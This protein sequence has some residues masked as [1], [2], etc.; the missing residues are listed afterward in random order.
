[1]R[2]ENPVLILITL[3]ILGKRNTNSGWEEGK[4]T[5]TCLS[6]PVKNLSTDAVYNAQD[7]LF[8][9]RVV[10]TD[11]FLS[12]IPMR[13]TTTEKQQEGKD[14]QRQIKLWKLSHT[15]TLTQGQVQSHRASYGKAEPTVNPLWN[16]RR[17]NTT[18]EGG[19]MVKGIQRTAGFGQVRMRGDCHDLL[20]W[21]ARSHRIPLVYACTEGTACWP[22]PFPKALMLSPLETGQGAQRFLVSSFHCLA[23]N[24]PITYPA[25]LG[26]GLSSNG[27]TTVIN[28]GLVTGT[29]GSALK[30]PGHMAA[31]SHPSY[32]A[33]HPIKLPARTLRKARF[34]PRLWVCMRAYCWKRAD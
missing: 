2:E 15:T 25:L 13:E 30:M 11:P 4:I 26:T 3:L 32:K 5:C 20:V 1:M 12:P 29:L 6:H 21:H 16:S 14:R 34:N 24:R 7:P 17:K 8:C 33:F 23:N 28:S 18:N 27:V 31:L 10:K 9:S 19:R 22:L